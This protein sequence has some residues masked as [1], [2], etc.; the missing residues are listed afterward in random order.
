MR[1]NLI[2]FLL[3]KGYNISSPLDRIKTVHRFWGFPCVRHQ[4]DHFMC[5]SFKPPNSPLGQYY[6]SVNIRKVIC[7]SEEHQNLNVLKEQRFLSRLHYSSNADKEECLLI[8]VIQEA[9]LMEDDPVTS[10]EIFKAS[11]DRGESRENGVLTLQYYSLIRTHAIS[12][13]IS[14]RKSDDRV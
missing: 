9:R 3:C 14:Q 7:R 10:T 11:Q 1:M 6:V 8:A 12:A 2:K 13:W 5:F 4:G